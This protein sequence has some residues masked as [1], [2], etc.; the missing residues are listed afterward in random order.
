MKAWKLV[1]FLVFDTPQELRTDYR[2][3]LVE[4]VMGEIKSPYAQ[5]VKSIP[6]ESREHMTR[7]YN[8][9]LKAGGEGIVLRKPDGEYQ[10]G[11]SSH[12]LKY[13]VNISCL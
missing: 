3:Q 13:K 10:F 1:K 9:I 6:C 7:F 11:R 5:M 2:L 8:E 12:M 4:D